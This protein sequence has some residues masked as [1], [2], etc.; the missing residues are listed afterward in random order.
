MKRISYRGRFVRPIGQ[1]LA[2]YS[3]VPSASLDKFRA[4]ARQTRVEA[5]ASHQ[6]LERWVALTGDPA[7]G[8]KAGQL[9][10]FGEGGVLDFAMR[11]ARSIREASEVANWHAD[12]YGDALTVALDVVG[13]RAL[14]RIG[15]QPAWPD[16]VA[17][18]LLSAWYNVHIS[19]Q[20]TAASALEC[21]FAHA[22]PPDIEPYR[23][24]FPMA[25]LKFGMP[26]CGF[27]FAANWLDE[28]LAS[29]DASLHTLHRSYLASVVARATEQRSL[30]PRV[31]E[32]IAAQMRRG[33]PTA[34]HVTR[35]LKISRRTLSRRLIEEGTSFKALL[36]E[37]RC[38]LALRFLAD[39]QLPLE[40]ISAQ[41]CFSRVQ[42][43]HRAF[44]RWSGATPGNY[45][46]L[47]AETLATVQPSAASHR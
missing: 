45:R 23:R 14:L 2:T 38:Q 34:A 4:L 3:V 24:A 17:D 8:V 18:F 43:F 21:W 1:Q 42:G 20:L 44:R 13:E 41:L 33:R 25:E 16:V 9:V 11:S 6:A 32:L 30:A 15:S 22:T 39:G 10:R 27:S 40:E 47:H 46:R 28:P 36:D 31:R 12:Q 37:L 35:R 7:L 29:A 5:V 19:R 26:H